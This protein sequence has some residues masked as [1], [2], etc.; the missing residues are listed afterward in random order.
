MNGDDA[1]QTMKGE[2]VAIIEAA[3]DSVQRGDDPDEVLLA[4]ELEVWF[5]GQAWKNHAA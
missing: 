5:L 1:K 3:L 4:Y 2:L